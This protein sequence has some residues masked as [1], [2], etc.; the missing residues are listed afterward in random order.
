MRRILFLTSALALSA[1]NS[2]SD[3]QDSGIQPIDFVGDKNA[4]EKMWIVSKNDYPIY[5]TD[6][7]RRGISGCVDFSFVI[8]SE[9]KA[10]NI[11][12]IKAIPD[13]TFISSA[14]KS[15]KNFRWQPTELNDKRQP[16]IT[17]LQLDFSTTRVM[18]VAECIAGDA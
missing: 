7:A 13:S 11:Q 10:Q 5:P 6:A 4:L 8:N 16:A 2:T 3:V 17:T 14:T 12:V 9:G 15:L 18:K 1:C